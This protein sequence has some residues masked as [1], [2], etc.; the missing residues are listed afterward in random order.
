M[1]HRW[2]CCLTNHHEPFDHR[3]L[4]HEPLCLRTNLH[5]PSVSQKLAWA[6]VAENDGSW[7]SVKSE[8]AQP[9]QSTL[10]TAMFFSPRYKLDV[11]SAKCVAA[12]AEHQEQ[13]DARH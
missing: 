1:T 2:L 13:I 3:T 10:S 6:N 7:R 4:L 9:L 11:R 12:T 5:E 8:A